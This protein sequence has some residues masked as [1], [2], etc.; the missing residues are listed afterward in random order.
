[1]QNVSI[2]KSNLKVLKTFLKGEFATSDA[3]TKAITWK[4]LQ[5][6]YATLSS[7]QSSLHLYK[8]HTLF[9]ATI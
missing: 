4:E 8:R 2:S 5:Q 9:L 1:M 7:Q 3:R 6:R